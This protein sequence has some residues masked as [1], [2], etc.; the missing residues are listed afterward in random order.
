MK[1]SA[2]VA[3]ALR[4]DDFKFPPLPNTLSEVLNLMASPGPEQDPDRLVEIVER[5]P[6]MAAH[7]LKRINSA[8]YGVSRQVAHVSRAVLML[9]F[10]T[11]C[12]LVLSVGLRQT[13]E[14]LE[15][16]EEQAVLDH[17]MK[18][19]IATA[20]FAR[21]LAVHL[22]LPMAETAFSAG[23]LHQVGRL[24]LLYTIPEAYTLLWCDRRVGEQIVVITPAVR[25]ERE[26]F[27]TDYVVVGATTAERW[28]LPEKLSTIIHHH[29]RP[30][31]VTD[32]H[33][34]ALTLA[35]TAGSLQ[36]RALFEGEAAADREACA[37]RPHLSALA[38][39][40]NQPVSSLEA[41]LTA[42]M[43]RIRQFALLALSG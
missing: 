11:V 9:G 39:M 30:N 28:H 6:V 19:S 22:H 38:G 7:V 4:D 23:L 43:D 15:G 21:E 26:F 10:K 2:P 12:N 40:R 24:I 35:V 16:D 8:Y 27:Q 14:E 41:M 29:A 32:T 42:Q 33:L 34:R 37:T 5:D 17:I 18:N 36:A 31:K 13:F 1:Q 25:K 3:Q 20:C